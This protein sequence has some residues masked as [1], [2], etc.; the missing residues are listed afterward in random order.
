LPT[1]AEWEYSCRAGTTAAYATGPVLRP[2]DANILSSAIGTTTTVGKYP[3]NA[4]GLYDMHGNVW[5]WCEDWFGDYPIAPVTDPTGPKRG[6]YRITRGGSF[7]NRAC[8]VRAADRN[9]IGPPF[10]NGATG[11]RVACE[12]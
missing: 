10:R 4:Y 8:I 5:E 1:E 12:P 2:E 3:C 11:F 9:I 6:K 7:I